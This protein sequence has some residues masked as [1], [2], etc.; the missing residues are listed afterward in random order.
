MLIKAR[1]SAA[2]ADELAAVAQ[3]A[4]AR[5]ARDEHLLADVGN[6]C[7][8]GI[9]R[10]WTNPRCV[11]VPRSA[12]AP[13]W[14]AHEGAR[15]PVVRRLSGG[16]AVPNGPGI[17]LISAILPH[18]AFSSPAPESGYQWFTALLVEALATLGIA[19]DPGP[20]AGSFCDGRHNIRVT[21]RKIAG[22]AQRW[23]SAGPFPSTLLH[24][25]LLTGGCRTSLTDLVRAVEPDRFLRADRHVTAME[26]IGDRADKLLDAFENAWRAR[27][28]GGSIIRDAMPHDAFLPPASMKLGSC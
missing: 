19:A 3:E 2:W 24:A 22:T 9:F 23:R 5:T 1:H 16:G 21:G 8:P 18:Y 12:V 25:V 28:P 27:V 20:V 11:V 14:V 7:A 13:D 4:A 17:L 6:G 15:V 26:L 10:L